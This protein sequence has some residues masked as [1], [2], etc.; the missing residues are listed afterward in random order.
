M[1]NSLNN[2]DNNLSNYKRK[3]DKVLIINRD[4]NKKLINQY[5]YFF[6]FV[7]SQLKIEANE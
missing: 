4:E 2:V 6:V 5:R 3:K 1:R 7:N